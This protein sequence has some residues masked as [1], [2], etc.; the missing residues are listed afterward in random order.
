MRAALPALLSQ[1][2][3]THVEPDRAECARQLLQFPAT[4]HLLKA[5]AH[6]LL[7]GGS[8]HRLPRLS[9]KVRV[10][11][12]S[13]FHMAVFLTPAHILLKIRMACNPNVDLID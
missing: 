1:V 11:I 7:N 13:R 9:E 6:S 4:D 12:Q 3:G 8:A 10:N 5:G 2:A